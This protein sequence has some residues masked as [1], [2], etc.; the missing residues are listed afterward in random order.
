MRTARVWYWIDGAGSLGTGTS[1]AD[2]AG[3]VLDRWGRE[4][5]D[6]VR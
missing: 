1:D 5:G 2:G 4:L 6:R 3:V